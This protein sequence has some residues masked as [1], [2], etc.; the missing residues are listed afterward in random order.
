MSDEQK[1]SSENE[2]RC[3]SALSTQSNQTDSSESTRSTLIKEI[4]TSDK[5]KELV[6]E[7]DQKISQ[8]VDHINSKK[9]SGRR[10]KYYTKKIVNKIIES[11]YSETSIN[12]LNFAHTL[13]S[14]TPY[15]T[16]KDSAKTSKLTIN[17]E[18]E[19]SEPN[20]PIS[21]ISSDVLVETPKI[22][23]PNH[24]NVATKETKT[25][26][27]EIEKNVSE[28]KVNLGSKT[29]DIPKETKHKTNH[30]GNVLE[31]ITVQKGMVESQ[32]TQHVID[33]KVN[34]GETILTLIV[35]N[36][37]KN[38]IIKPILENHS[39][40]SKNSTQTT[41]SNYELNLN[42]LDSN[43]SKSSKENSDQGTSSKEISLKDEDN[44]KEK[45][46]SKDKK[47]S[48]DVKSSEEGSLTQQY[49]KTVRNILR[50]TLT[51]IE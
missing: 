5:S 13:P 9:Y 6:N 19:K 10:K 47:R 22:Y 38:I 24:L 11:K 46:I 12:T 27:T 44:H 36:G 41:D 4:L 20:N 3:E 1:E 26:I 30:T 14:S 48:K 32:K 23:S 42:Q 17:N 49:K 35:K 2:T 39:E 37:D 21:K 15:S 33:E 29:L 50:I 8:L 7:I 51:P 45:F 43:D 34:N 16:E 31:I 28:V 25:L 18:N 40:K